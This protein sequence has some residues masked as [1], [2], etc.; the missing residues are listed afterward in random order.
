M[1]RILLAKE[2][3]EQ[4]RTAKLLIMAAVLFVM[5]LVS[6]I[7]A[8]YT[9]QLLASVPNMPFDLS[10]LLPEP[11]IK[12]A[13]AQYVKNISQFGV[14]LAIL[15]TMGTLA[16]EKERGTAAMLL[17]KPVRRSYVVLSKWLSGML[18]LMVSLL[19]AGIA[20]AVYTVILF[21]SIPLEGFV[22]LNLLL[23]LYLGVYLTA[24]LLASALARTQAM[25][26]A[27][28]FG[29]LALL[30]IVGAIPRLGYYGPGK[31]LAWGE[32]VVLA[33]DKPAPAWGALVACIAFI[34][35]ALVI[36]CWRFEREE[37]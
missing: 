15:L 28:A 34:G 21:G 32:L 5:G 7:L 36:A 27:G 30:L 26:A 6:P 24:G 33:G 20:G 2:W 31:L 13:I 37:I 18:V 3:L 8:K 14:L 17:T 4:R 12:D 16:Q 10:G 11:T 29:M 25:A 19:L 35:V 9:P 22:Y 1:F 23:V